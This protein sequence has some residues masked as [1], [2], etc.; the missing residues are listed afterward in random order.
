[1][2]SLQDLDNYLRKFALHSALIEIG[3]ISTHLFG[4]KKVLENFPIKI[5][6]TEEHATI[7]QWHLAFL[8]YRLVMVSND[9][10]SSR[11]NSKELLSANS[12]FA[13][14]DDP[15]GKE[16]DIVAFL[17]RLS[18][19][20]FWWQ[21]NRKYSFARNYILLKEIP[22]D[23]TFK[24]RIKL[25][26]V[27][28]KEYGLSI[29]DYTAIGW[30]IVTICRKNPFF[31]KNNLLCHSIPAYKDILT[32]NKLDK[33]LALTSATYADIRATSRSLNT[34][35]LPHYEKYQFNPLFKY[36]IVE[37]DSRF[38]RSYFQEPYIVPNILLFLKKIADGVYWDLRDIFKE[39]ESREF[40]RLFGDIFEC[41]VGK[42]LANYFG[43]SNVKKL[44]QNIGEK[45]KIA[46]WAVITDD[47]ITIFEC[48]SQLLPLIIRET[49]NEHKL[50]EWLNRNII[51]G[52]E[53]LFST[54]EQL[55]KGDSLGIK[56]ANKKIYKILITYENIYLIESPMFKDRIK[57]Y[58]KDKGIFEQYSHNSSDFY[59]MHI[60]ELEFMQNFLK[61]FTIKN[62]LEEKKHIDTKRDIASGHDFFTVCHNL[63]SNIKPSNDWL[64]NTFKKY[65]DK[66]N[67]KTEGK[68]R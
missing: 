30:A 60:S 4:D 12:I 48:K 18:Q 32:E 29:Y 43:Q 27:F 37:S 54:E 55:L 38:L 34:L 41:Y 25:D 65:F 56:I 26:E 50:R 51:S 52:I 63:D 21:V 31:K 62:I 16:K 7:A 36:P 2:R 11:L 44:P 39:K 28:L 19:E 57:K 33:F 42:I 45:I 35:I 49:F 17:C 14:F 1:M 9:G 10:R 46:D 13:E 47:S 5:G 66:F 20:Q 40:L 68:K 58:V 15:L 6:N 24:N 22:R 59:I 3:K 8:A 61:K 23:D 64:H 53:Q 67:L